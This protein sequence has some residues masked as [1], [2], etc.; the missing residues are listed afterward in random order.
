MKNPN[1]YWLWKTIIWFPKIIN[2]LGNYLLG[3][4]KTCNWSNKLGFMYI[5]YIVLD[6]W[7][8]N[9]FD[10]KNGFLRIGHEVGRQSYP[11]ILFMECSLICSKTHKKKLQSG[12]RYTIVPFIILFPLQEWIGMIILSHLHETPSTLHLCITLYNNDYYWPAIQDVSQRFDIEEILSW[13][14][15]K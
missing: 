4:I 13:S 12:G 8:M 14:Y 3:S 15:A 6:R 5:C 9:E 2:I 10:D 7:K 1:Y 11:Y